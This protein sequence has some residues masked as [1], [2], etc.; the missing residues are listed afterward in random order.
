MYG[1]RL[2]LVTSPADVVN[3]LSRLETALSDSY[4]DVWLKGGA[5]DYV[6]DR[7]TRRFGAEGDDVVGAWPAL[8]PATVAIRQSLG[9]PGPSPINHR[10]G[11]M[12]DFLI[13]DFGLVTGSG[14][15]QL[16]FPSPS[17][18]SSIKDKLTTAQQGSSNPN[19]VPRPVLGLNDLDA[20]FLTDDL[21]IFLA[22][23]L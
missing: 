9:Y 18:S 17:M 21:G 7:I 10:T 3:A 15:M 20:E 13:G 8:K 2:Q 23:G 14:D 22:R 12:E 1:L 4:L 11:D 16:E 5:V 19:T 6:K